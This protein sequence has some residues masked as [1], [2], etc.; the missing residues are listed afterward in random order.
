[1]LSGGFGVFFPGKLVAILYDS[2]GRQTGITT[3]QT[4]SPLEFVML[5]SEIAA[6]PETVRVSLH[7]LDEQGRD[8][9][10]LGEAKVERGSKDL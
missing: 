4:V 7:L 2:R 1:M 9:G 5:H 8:E 6:A 10:S 3:L